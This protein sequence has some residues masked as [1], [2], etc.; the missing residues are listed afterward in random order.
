MTTQSDAGLKHEPY[1][2]QDSSDTALVRRGPRRP[3]LPGVSGNPG[4]RPK[5]L[6]RFIREQ[7]DDGEELARFMLTILRDERAKRADRITA[8]TWLADRGFGKP[9]AAPDTNSS[10]ATMRYSHLAPDHLRAAVDVLDG[11]LSSPE[12]EPTKV[13]AQGS[14]QESV[15]GSGLSAN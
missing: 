13:S 9:L 11:V 6:D 4:G 8:A 1:L 2:A 10:Q 15:A 7:T 12:T 5:G 3:F 14:A